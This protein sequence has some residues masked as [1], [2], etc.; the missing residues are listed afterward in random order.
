MSKGPVDPRLFKKPEPTRELQSDAE[1]R[2]ALEQFFL[3][4]AEVTPAANR[5]RCKEYAHAI[6]AESGASDEA[7]ELARSA[8]DRLADVECLL[9]RGA[10]ESHINAGML[11]GAKFEAMR[12]SR[13]FG[14]AVDDVRRRNAVIDSKRIPP[15]RREKVL[16]WWS[17]NR[18]E[19]P[20]DNAAR[21]ACAIA[22]GGKPSTVRQIVDATRN[23]A[24]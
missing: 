4:A 9:A 23:K 10:D 20:S 14:K 19:Y 6:L 1:K 5:K 8:L 17:H 16:A 15:E 7:K 18:S 13:I 3:A 11:L 21:K 2:E 24:R 12:L 22:L